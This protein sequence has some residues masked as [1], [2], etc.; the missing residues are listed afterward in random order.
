M[1]LDDGLFFIVDWNFLFLILGGCITA[2]WLLIR[3]ASVSDSDNVESLTNTVALI[4]FPVGILSF[5]LAGAGIYLDSM[6][7]GIP[8]SFDIVTLICLCLMGLVLILRPIKDFKFGTFISLAIGLFGAALLIFLGANQVKIV[9][10]AFIALFL[11]IY[12]T[13]RMIEDLY[14]L[15][16]EIL[17]MP[18]ISVSVGLICIVQGLLQMIG[19][20]FLDILAGIL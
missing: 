5:M 9:A 8:D 12:L 15:I 19:G 1:S 20:S 17:S 7:I 16:A 10:G 13:I 4:G 14:L 6:E 3:L 18:I 11:I 2:S